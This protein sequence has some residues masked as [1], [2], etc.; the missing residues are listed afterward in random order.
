MEEIGI[1]GILVLLGAIAWML[2]VIVEKLE[3]I[4]RTLRGMVNK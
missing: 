1:A 3:S 2:F 4:D